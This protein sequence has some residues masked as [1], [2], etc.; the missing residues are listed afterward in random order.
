MLAVLAALVFITTFVAVALAVLVAWFTS[1]R[2]SAESVTQASAMPLLE[3]TSGI[4]KNDELSTISIWGKLLERFDFVEILRKHLA[5]ADLAWS[6]GRL[7]ALMLLSGTLSIVVLANIR[8]VPVWAAV[9]FGAGG[10]AA[11]YLWVLQ[12]RNKRVRKFE[13][14]F[15]EALDSLAR[16]LRSGHPFAAAVEIVVAEAEAPVSTE[17]K[18]VSVEGNFGT[19]W[20][21]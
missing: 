9:L 18:K 19:S 5:Q 21:Q 2:F 7:T 3:N 6:V 1:Q 15:P 10:T 14:D 12:R 16:A 20:E 4:F 17:L 11:P 13:E 8:W